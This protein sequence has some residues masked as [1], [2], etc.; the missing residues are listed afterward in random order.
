LLSISQENKH[1]FGKQVEDHIE[2]LNMLISVEAGNTLGGE[3]VQRAVLAT[4]LLEGSA[5]MIGMTDWGDVLSLFRELMENC[6]SSE[7]VWDD[8]LSQVVL[9]ILESEERVVANLY[10]GD[11]SEVAAS[12]NFISLRKEIELVLNE[13]KR[14]SQEKDLSEEKSEKTEEVSIN[15][16]D[17]ETEPPVNDRTYSIM[18]GLTK[19]VQ[20]IQDHLNDYLV[21]STMR[22]EIVER[23]ETDFGECE[24]LVSLVSNIVG[25]LGEDGKHFCSRVSSKVISD[26]LNDFFAFYQQ[27]EGWEAKLKVSSGDF[28]MDRDLASH[29]VFILGKCVYDICSRYKNESKFKL[30]VEVEIESKD[31]Y[32]MVNVKDN[33]PD[34]LS[35]S[36]LDKEDAVAF[37]KGL[38][39]VK[40]LLEKIGGLLWVEPDDGQRARFRFTLLTSRKEGDYFI[41]NAS[42]KQVAIP[43]CNVADTIDVDESQIGGDQAEKYVVV[44]GTKL[45]FYSLEELASE[46]VG[47]ESTYDKLIIAGLVERRIGILCGGE[48]KREVCLEEQL[49]MEDWCGIADQT[50]HVGEREIP[51]L[52]VG[53]ILTRA[54]GLRSLG[55]ELKEVGVCSGEMEG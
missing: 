54:D 52:D 23:L 11:S 21:E 40:N 46:K 14:L 3:V 35:D 12:C 4:K 24:F 48:I 26:G 17:Q 45:P 15:E 51:V 44:K 2:K 1:L 18:D 41:I 30:N 34:F 31:Y 53:K 22:E 33:G 32:L 50:L 5:R 8:Q 16:N 27:A 6:V 25:E 43:S 29:L 38:L 55:D 7:M 19:S 42:G 37:Y 13:G 9:D 39:E 36:E 28:Y 10:H 47:S 20:S 49:I